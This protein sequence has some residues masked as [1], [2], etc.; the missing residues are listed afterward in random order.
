[1]ESE[2]YRAHILDLYRHPR[3][4]GT[5]KNAITSKVHNSL[6]GDELTL[7]IDIMHEIITDVR[8]VGKGCA[9]SIASASLFTDFIKGKTI[10]EVK[11]ISSDEVLKLLKIDI[12]PVRMKCALLIVDALQRS[13]DVRN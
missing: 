10:K 13:I 1:M 5:L 12:S 6:C 7:Y 2:M 8:F 4:F 3:N 9:I 11:N